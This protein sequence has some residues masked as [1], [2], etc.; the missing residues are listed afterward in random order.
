MAKAMQKLRRCEICGRPYLQHCVYCFI[1]ARNTQR[2]ALLEELG[3][4]DEFILAKLKEKVDGGSL[5]ALTIVMELKQ[6]HLMKTPPSDAGEEVQKASLIGMLEEL[7]ACED[8][9]DIGEKSEREVLK[10][11]AP[12]KK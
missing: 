1:Q 5:S 12:P 9:I 7:E 10:L 8:A 2:A 3:V 4:T 6:F 11:P